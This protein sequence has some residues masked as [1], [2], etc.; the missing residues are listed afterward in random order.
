VNAPP[1]TLT[2][3]L[4]L[5]EQ[6]WRD[7]EKDYRDVVPGVCFVRGQIDETQNEGAPPL[8]TWVFGGGPIGPPAGDLIGTFGVRKH[9]L[10]V[11]FW[12]TDDRQAEWMFC[13]VS[14][15]AQQ[16][17][18]GVCT[19]GN[20]DWTAGDGKYARNGFVIRASLNLRLPLAFLPDIAAEPVMARAKGTI[21]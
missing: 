10:Q 9:A 18:S 21:E 1:V 13:Q 2:G 20:E 11:H 12:G 4:D 17:S 16:L 5:I 19:W 7:R 3:W 15:I 14:A 8:V 6:M